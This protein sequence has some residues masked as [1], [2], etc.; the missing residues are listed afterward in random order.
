VPRFVWVPFAV[1]LAGFVLPFATV[2]C[3]ATRFEPTGAELVLRSAPES[4]CV[5]R[6]CVTEEDPASLDVD[7]G[8]IVVELAG[9]LAT[10][11]F[12]GF[13]FALV[14]ARIETRGGWTT[15]AGAVGVAALLFLGTRDYGLGGGPDERDSRSGATGAWR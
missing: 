13:A 11:A 5:G 12:L 15:L 10:A 2:S 6:T 14:V 7:L 4:E 9:G 3:G 8:E 1:A